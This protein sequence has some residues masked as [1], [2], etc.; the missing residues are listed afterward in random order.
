S[1][2][3]HVASQLVKAMAKKRITVHGSRVLVLGLTFKENTPDV[4]NSKV[5]DVISELESFDIQVEA[6]DPWVEPN[7]ISSEKAVALI[8]E[9]NHHAYDAI[10]VA[11]AHDHF[12]DKPS[13]DLRKYGKT[14]KHVLFDLKRA[15]G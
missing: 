7:M 10:V 14:N 9:P 12:T 5:F 3:E 8:D 2:S 15:L 4:C 6:Y 13:A 11:V 1:M